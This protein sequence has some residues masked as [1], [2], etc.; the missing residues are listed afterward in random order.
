MSAAD[1]TVDHLR[2]AVRDPE[3]HQRPLH[4]FREVLGC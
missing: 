3:G 4:A 1:L 2:V